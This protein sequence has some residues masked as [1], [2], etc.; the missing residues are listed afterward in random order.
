[1]KLIAKQFQVLNYR[2]IDDSG[3]IPLERVT[4]FVGRNESGKTALL[5]ALHKFNPAIEEP[6][7][8]HREFPSRLPR[9]HTLHRQVV[10]L[11]RRGDGVP[12]RETAR[13]SPD[14]RIGSLPHH[15]SGGSAGAGPRPSRHHRA[16]RRPA[17]AWRQLLTLSWKRATTDEE[18]EGT[19]DLHTTHLPMTVF[20]AA[21]GYT[22]HLEREWVPSRGALT[23]ELEVL[24]EGSSI[25]FS[26]ACYPPSP[27]QLSALI[28]PGLLLDTLDATATDAVATKA[29]ARA[30]DDRPVLG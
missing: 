14:R 11:E 12:I 19:V 13:I 18:G 22:A 8:A 21:P 25:I 23:I 20:P 27:I 16:K 5:K 4:A 3:W 15:P 17:P 26:E 29:T 6:Y 24:R 1:M 28:P 2:N 9:C 10:P 7:N 30:L